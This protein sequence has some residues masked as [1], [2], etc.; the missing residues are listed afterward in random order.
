MARYSAEILW[1]RDEQDFLDNRYS[2]A[3]CWRFDGGLEL[4][5]VGCNKQYA[6]KG[7]LSETP[8][9]SAIAYLGDDITDEDGAD[10]REE[11][12]RHGH[13]QVL[14]KALDFAPVR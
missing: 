6:V 5:A 12:A 2:R 11:H 3:H 10:G 9:E 7:V 13:L 4:R 8:Q 1:L 14:E